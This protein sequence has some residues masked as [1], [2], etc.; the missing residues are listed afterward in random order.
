MRRRLTP[1]QSYMESRL[2][3]KPD[4]M[5]LAQR[6][7]AKHP[8]S[9][10]FFQDSLSCSPESVAKAATWKR[11]S[12]QHSPGIPRPVWL[13]SPARSCMRRILAPLRYRGGI[14]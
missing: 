2:H 13:L 4:S 7:Q 12:A 8:Q 5:R 14:G 11:P 1:N 6:H 3:T 10:R 9:T